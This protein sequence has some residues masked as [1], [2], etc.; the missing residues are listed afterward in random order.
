L[1]YTL[2]VSGFS[3]RC[4]GVDIHPACELRLPINLVKGTPVDRDPE[5][6]RLI[7]EPAIRRLLASYTRAIDRQDHD[8]LASLFHP[9]AIDEHGPSTDQRKASSSSC[10]TAKRLDIT[11]CITTA[12]S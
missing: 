7:D 6:Q 2:H 4:Q 1:A 3:R 12:P 9:D 5:V 11:G 8:L 10:A